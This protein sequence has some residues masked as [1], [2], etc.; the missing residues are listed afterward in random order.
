MEVLKRLTEI[1]SER[2]RLTFRTSSADFTSQ[3]ATQ[4]FEGLTLGENSGR[5]LMQRINPMNHPVTQDLE[6][7]IEAETEYQEKFQEKTSVDQQLQTRQREL[8]QA[9]QDAISAMQVS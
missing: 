1:K 8:Q 6:N 9:E 7:F 4:Y 3:D 5:T 2:L